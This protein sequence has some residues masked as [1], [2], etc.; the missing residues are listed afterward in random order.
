MQE[1]TR[2]RFIKRRGMKAWFRRATR[3]GGQRSASSPSRCRWRSIAATRVRYSENA[4]KGGKHRAGQRTISGMEVTA[5]Q[6]SHTRMARAAQLT[7]GWRAVSHHVQHMLGHASPQQ[8]STYLN[9]TLTGLHQSRRKME[10]SRP[11][12]TPLAQTRSRGPRPVGKQT[13]IQNGTSLSH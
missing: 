11:A 6:A 4:H 1:P 10:Q 8:T 7:T 5:P 13:S 3:V 9:T 12:C 2:Q